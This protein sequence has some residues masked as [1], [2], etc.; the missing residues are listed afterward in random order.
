MREAEAWCA[1]VCHSAALLHP[2]EKVPRG[3]AVAAAVPGGGWGC[4]DCT[5]FHGIAGGPSFSAETGRRSGQ[6]EFCYRSIL[7]N[8]NC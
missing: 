8:L 6:E 4:A 2:G 1:L 7:H 3:G 5:G